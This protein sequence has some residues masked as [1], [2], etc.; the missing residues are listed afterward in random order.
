MAR[1]NGKKSEPTTLR[2]RPEPTGPA[3]LERQRTNALVGRH[4]ALNEAFWS[5]Q[6]HRD[7]E[8]NFQE[9]IALIMEF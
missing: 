8:R 4:K 6:S 2:V 5:L 7:R 9:R 1:K 3:V